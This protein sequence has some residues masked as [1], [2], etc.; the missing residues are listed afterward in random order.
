[1]DQQLFDACQQP[2]CG[3]SAAIVRLAL[4]ENRPGIALNFQGCSA[5][6][7]AHSGSSP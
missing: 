2:V 1:M 4:I 7:S 5:E 3:L 6:E